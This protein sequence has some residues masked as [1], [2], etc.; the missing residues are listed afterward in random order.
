MPVAQLNGIEINYEEHGAGT[1]VVLA[2]GYTASLEMWREQRDALAEKYRLVI[3]D[4]RGHGGTTT[5][6]STAL[7]ETTS[8]ISSR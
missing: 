4:T 6:S 8:A 2:H 5:W 7:R 1:P 3:Y